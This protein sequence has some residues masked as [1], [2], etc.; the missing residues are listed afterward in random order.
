MSALSTPCLVLDI[1]PP[2]AA[3]VS[4]WDD[5]PYTSLTRVTPFLYLG[6][7]AAARNVERLHAAGVTDI[8]SL[9]SDGTL[10]PRAVRAAF[11]CD[12][13]ELK[14]A[15]D[16]PLLSRLPSLVASI[17]ATR[18]KGGVVLVHCHGG[19]SRSPAVVAAF[20]M[21]HHGWT[22]DKALAHLR[23]LRPCIDP[24]T[25]FLAALEAWEVKL[26]A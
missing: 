25:G 21:T 8:I 3:A 18:D 4:E 7:L 5:E 12:R 2:P 16:A 23:T 11:A 9:V 22:R 20:L 14:D 15:S 24:N 6:D 17:E 10:L 19:V 13:F 1:P 26:R